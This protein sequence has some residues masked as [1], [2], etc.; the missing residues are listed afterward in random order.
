M[1][2]DEAFEGELLGVSLPLAAAWEA[3]EDGLGALIGFE[4]FSSGLSDPVARLAEMT[5]HVAAG[6]PPG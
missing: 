2:S 4:L 6:C 5:A 3:S 1:P